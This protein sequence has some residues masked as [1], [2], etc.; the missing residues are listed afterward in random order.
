MIMITTSELAG[1]LWRLCG[2]IS[3]VV[4]WLGQL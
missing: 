3:V 2:A 4:V 1:T